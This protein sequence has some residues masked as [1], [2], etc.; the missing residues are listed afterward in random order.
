MSSSYWNDFAPKEATR[1]CDNPEDLV[2]ERLLL[3]SLPD[4]LGPDDMVLDIGGGTGRFSL[5]VAPLVRRIEH[6]DLAPRMIEI[7]AAAAQR[8]GIDNVAF[9]M[10]DA[11][12]LSRYRDRS[13]TKVLSINTPITFSGP[14]WR[15]TVEEMCRV[16][17]H[18]ALFIVANFLSCLAALID[19]SLAANAGW[20]KVV[21]TMVAHRSMDAGHL[22]QL[23]RTFPS[24]R[25]FAPGEE[26]EELGRHGFEVVSARGLA[27]LC[28][29]LRRESLAAIVADETL[30]AHFLAAEET[31]ATVYE[32]WA[33]SRETLFHVRRAG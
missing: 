8:R 4:L 21:E 27:V 10:A 30:L 7:A 13:F 3:R 1:G 20:S 12:D 9:T 19:V 25:A 6:V 29:L 18:E 17:E 14:E 28:R 23:G 15:R 5:A 26:E 11:R 2:Y 24:Y 31:I 32:R 16:T 22:S 33:P